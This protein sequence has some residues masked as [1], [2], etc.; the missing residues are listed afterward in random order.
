[1][2]KGGVENGGGLFSVPQEVNRHRKRKAISMLLRNVE[3]STQ[4][5]GSKNYKGLLWVQE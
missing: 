3:V 1:M 5:N 4:E 2:K